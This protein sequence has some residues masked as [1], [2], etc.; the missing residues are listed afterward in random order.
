MCW[1]LVDQPRAAVSLRHVCD[2]SCVYV[3]S[4]GVG[5]WW[6]NPELLV[7]CDMSGLTI[8]PGDFVVTGHERP[9]AERIMKHS[10]M[11]RDGME[12]VS[13]YLWV[14][15]CLYGTLHSVLVCIYDSVT[16][17]SAEHFVDLYF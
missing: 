17:Y 3:I 16:N 11:W 10:T 6:I 8:E 4:L 14:K 1:Q 9:L 13:D 2:V 12:K 5:S 15:R 7:H